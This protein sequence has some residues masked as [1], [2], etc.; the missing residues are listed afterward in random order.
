MQARNISRSGE[1]SLAR[2]NTPRHT[3]QMS[4]I[5]CYGYANYLGELRVRVAINGRDLTLDETEARELL[6]DLLH[7]LD[8]DDE[9]EPSVLT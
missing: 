1:L 9:T 5:Q 6:A 7:A 3:Y 2:S 4:R 8:T